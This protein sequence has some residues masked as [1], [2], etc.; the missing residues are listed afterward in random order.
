MVDGVGVGDVGSIVL[1]DRKVLATEGAVVV[2]VQFDRGT[3]KVSGNPEIITRGFVYEGKSKDLLTKS[4]Q[5]LS[6]SLNSKK[7]LNE[8]IIKDETVNF[9]ESYFYKLTARR[10]MILPVV[11]EV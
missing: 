4:S 9:L 5:E 3:K 10:P 8:R 1:R 7:D 2:I 6:R 11:I